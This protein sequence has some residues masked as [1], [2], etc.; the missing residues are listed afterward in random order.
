MRK[1]LKNDDK[2]F[3]SPSFVTIEKKKQKDDDEPGR[4]TIIYYAWEK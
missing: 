4:L 1:K 3:D 2:P